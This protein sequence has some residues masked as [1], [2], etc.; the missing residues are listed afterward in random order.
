M[1]HAGGIIGAGLGLLGLAV[2]YGC[3]S[4]PVMSIAEP[5]PVG[6]SSLDELLGGPGR[7]GR[8]G[9]QVRGADPVPMTVP[10][11]PASRPPAVPATAEQI[12]ALVRDEPINATLTPQP[13]FNFLNTLFREVLGVPYTLGPGIA[14]RNDTLTVN[15]PP[16]MS[17][18]Q[19]VALVQSALREQGMT[20]S[21]TANGFQVTENG[22]TPGGGAATPIIRS[23]DI[24]QTPMTNQPVIQY[25]QLV[26]VRADAII[27][28][29]GGEGDVKR[30]MNVPA[31]SDPA[32]NAIVLQGQGRQVAAAVEFL[33]NVDQPAFAGAQVTRLEPVFWAPDAFAQQLAATL[34]AE[35]FI[36]AADPLAEKS[37][38]IL[39]MAST[40]QMLVFAADAATMSRVLFWAR[41]LDQ[42]SSVGADNTT[43]VYEVRNTSAAMIVQTLVN[44][45]NMA[46]RAGIGPGGGGFNN[47]VQNAVGAPG[48][49]PQQA[50]R[51]GGANNQ[52]QGRGGQAAGGNQG[53]GGAA[54]GGAQGRGGGQGRGGQ[55]ANQFA[56]RAGQGI[57]GAVPTGGVVT[58]DEGSNRILFTG[59]AS[60]FAQLRGLLRQLDMPA[61]Q[62]LVEVT[63]AEVTLTD[64]TR[65]GIEFFVDVLEAS[66]G[67]YSFG[68][69]ASTT[70]A[71]LGLGN[72]GLGIFLENSPNLDL[73]IN[74]FASNS[75]VNVL[76]RPRLAMRSGISAQMNVGTQVPIVVG[77]DVTNTTGDPVVRNNYQYRDTGVLLQVTPTIYGD[78][79]VDLQIYQQVS[80]VQANPDPDVPNPFIIQR[81]AETTL[82]LADGQTAVLG[83]LIQDNYAKSNRGIPL[84]KDI[85]IVGFPFRADSVT[86]EKTELV[87]LVTPYIIRN[88]GDMREMTRQMIDEFNRAFSSGRGSSYTLTPFAAGLSIADNPPGTTITGS[89]LRPPQGAVTLTPAP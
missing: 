26:A 77:Q 8:G 5:P 55:N 38:M 76:S 7:A 32:A 81:E 42:P 30:I 72:S 86:G 41:E 31:T 34:Q 78:N 21:A 60:Q 16:S 23:R 67:T 15:A 74:A 88:E 17:K 69:M 59:S 54:A 62:V 22:A 35:G 46:G 40:N 56:G 29:F 24:S 3:A 50:G 53:R 11:I 12:A 82:S 13:P 63:I 66:G 28:A 68:T 6:S 84:L 70:S 85:P 65:S 19:Y 25:F 1:K 44:A 83:G 18:R 64:E 80:D 9:D 52:N 2:L 27:T 79:Q 51:G 4:F 43:F 73:A 14:S 49:Q 75:K 20:L 47:V 48:G 61:R 39:P 45:G 36:V 37:I 58:L 87:I 89:S 71:G 10:G 57:G 33:R